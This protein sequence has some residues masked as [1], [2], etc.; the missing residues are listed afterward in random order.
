MVVAMGPVDRMYIPRTGE[1][2]RGLCLGTVLSSLQVSWQSQTLN[3]LLNTLPF[4]L[5]SYNLTCPLSIICPDQSSR[6]V[7]SMEVI[8]LVAS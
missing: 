7:I 8:H 2:L 4:M 6:G 3:D 5:V 1:Q